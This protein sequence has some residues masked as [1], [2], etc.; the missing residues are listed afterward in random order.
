MLNAQNLEGCQLYA[1]ANRS[2]PFALA[3]AVSHTLNGITSFN[4]RS[5]LIH[6]SNDRGMIQSLHEGYAGYSAQAYAVT[7]KDA[8]GKD[9]IVTEYRNIQRP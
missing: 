4:M 1:R 6:G 5:T 9:Y 2:D 8:D 7:R 3:R